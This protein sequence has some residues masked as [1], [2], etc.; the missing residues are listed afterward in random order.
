MKLLG[1]DNVEQVTVNSGR[2]HERTRGVFNVEGSDAQLLKAS[3]DFA[4]VGTTFQGAQGFECPQC[5]RINVFK[6]S[7]G[8]CG[9]RL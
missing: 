1:S 8:G 5:T 7:C 6:D 4:V 3:G 9:W 2:V